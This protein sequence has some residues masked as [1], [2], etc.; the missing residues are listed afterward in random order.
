VIRSLRHFGLVVRDLEA[1]LAF[2]CDVL[3]L[4]VIRRMDE[5]GAFL[6]AVLAGNGVRVTTVKLG[7]ESGPT[8]LE[9]LYFQKPLANEVQ[10]PS[11]FQAGPTHFAVTVT[12]LRAVHETLRDRGAVF[13]S[14]PECSP[15]GRAL[16][17]FGR[18]PEGNLIEFVEEL[19]P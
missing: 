11:L 6:D 15:D 18:D 8:L 12:D 19:M 2:Y 3:G 17:C 5:E 14:T 7:A 13:L 10:V 16:V 1:S 9:L 4:R